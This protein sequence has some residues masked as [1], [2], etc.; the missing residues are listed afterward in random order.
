MPIVFFAGPG[1]PKP[2]RDGGPSARSGV[3][4]IGKLAGIEA[5]YRPVAA[6]VEDVE[7]LPTHGSGYE[8][9]DAVILSTSRPRD[10]RQA[11]GQE[12]A[13]PGVGRVDTHGRAAGGVRRIAG[14][15]GDVGRLAA[16]DFFGPGRF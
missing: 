16:R 4:E 8:G 11:D 3:E 9:V 2:D 7:R 10:L 12:S 5:D 13:D 1:V 6:R 14:G 15:N